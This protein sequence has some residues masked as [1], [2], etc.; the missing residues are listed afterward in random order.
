MARKGDQDIYTY[1]PK[2]GLNLISGS[3]MRYNV[4]MV[5][6]GAEGIQRKR[7]AAEQDRQHKVSGERTDHGQ[8]KDETDDHDR[9]VR[10]DNDEAAVDVIRKPADRPLQS[11]AAQN[12]E[13][14]EQRD[15]RRRYADA[16][17]IERPDAPKRAERQAGAEA[18]D[19][20]ER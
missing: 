18:P 1:E 16:G 4:D 5:M 15:A 3:R 19:D 20:S 9:E 11:D 14:H 6:G 13:A 2:E 12:R 7:E 17:G 8:R 10:P